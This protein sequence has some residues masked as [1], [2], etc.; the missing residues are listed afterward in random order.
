M[1]TMSDDFLL[2]DSE[3]EVSK[4]KAGHPGSGE[5][6]GDGEDDVF[7]LDDGDSGEE[8]KAPQEAGD[9]TEEEPAQ[10]KEAETRHAHLDDD[11]Y[12]QAP[13]IEFTKV[14]IPEELTNEWCLELIKAI[15]ISIL[16]ALMY[17]PD[18]PM[19]FKVL[20][21]SF[22]LIRSLADEYEEF[23][24]GTTE[25]KLF[26]ENA[27]MDEKDMAVRKFI[28]ILKKMGMDSVSFSSGIEVRELAKLFRILGMK[29]EAV[30]DQGGV[31]ALLT[32]SEAPHIKLEKARYERIVE[33]EAVVKI[34]EGEKLI[35][36]PEGEKVTVGDASAGK[37]GK[38]K[39]QEVPVF[40]LA[41]EYFK[42]EIQDISP[43]DEQRM[44][45]EVKK[46]PR[47]FAL[48]MI[49]IGKEIQN[50]QLVVERLG[51]LFVEHVG[52]SGGKEKADLSKL[53]MSIGKEIQK[54]MLHT[55]SAKDIGDSIQSLG[56]AVSR[57]TDAIKINAI[58]A[59]YTSGKKRSAAKMET[60]LQ[61]IIESDKEK[62][63]LLPQITDRLL[64][65]GMDEGKVK[66]FSKDIE[67]VQVGPKK[68]I[69]VEEAEL[70]S[71]LEYK[72]QAEQE[73]EKLRS[74]EKRLQQADHYLKNLT[75]APQGAGQGEDASAGSF[76]EERIDDIA[77]IAAHVDT[78]ALK[79][80]RPIDASE[81]EDGRM[82]VSKEDFEDLMKRSEHFDQLLN[83]RLRLATSRLMQEKAQIE[84]E[85]ET[86]NALIAKLAQGVIVV[87]EE[88]RVVLMNRY[89]EELLG[90]SREEM[91]G[92]HILD[93]IKDEHL[94][95]LA[96]KSHRDRE[97]LDMGDHIELSAPE[98][99][100]RKTI[101]S[102]TA[103]VQ[104]Q[105]G[106]TVGMLFVLTDVEKQR[107]LEALK[108]NFIDKISDGL[109]RPLQLIQDT[110]SLVANQT[111]GELNE[112]QQ[113]LVDITAQNIKRLHQ[114]I[115]QLV[116]MSRLKTG[117]IVLEKASHNI[118][119]VIKEAVEPFGQWASEK[120]IDIK[121]HLPKEPLIGLFDSQRIGQV[122]TNLVSN[123][124]N[125]SAQNTSVSIKAERIEKGSDQFISVAVSDAGEGI[126]PSDLQNIFK[127][128][129]QVRTATASRS[130]GMGLGLA[131]CRELIEL[132]GGHIWAE[133]EWG[134]G[135]I[136]TFLI[137]LK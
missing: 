83:E 93:G 94:V 40:Q 114:Q 102:S 92:R 65:M 128:F 9:G 32:Q 60:Y 67:K 79:A 71:L 43:E 63:R 89:A 118:A 106:R 135:S 30:E 80:G 129:T 10:Q 134:R 3:D 130:A 7:L 22:T 6:A 17:P 110:V 127:E 50:L 4:K 112:E 37:D 35:S 72:E 46:D 117:D 27:L 23:T 64:A 125:F 57:C 14:K 31:R 24:I 91:I 90:V 18:H 28:S 75:A 26:V 111:A 44:V 11:D 126:P 73:L 45:K 115:A 122:L 84:H 42:G 103:M 39:E 86:L 97:D 59:K 121:L 124:I 47:R 107:E 1:N 58:I 41:A 78:G 101:Q 99:S 21:N 113:R 29:P 34:N 12:E 81:L 15:N 66:K 48:L 88:D 87:D 120:K 20:Q 25:G 13:D 5:G 104:D 137:P 133:S 98:D 132:H 85:R 70:V 49:Q 119:H 56:D 36:V 82:A 95:A 116:D 55:G 105:H 131:L 2:P 76:S 8:E 62:N 61:K 136:F 77:R 53:M 51:K 19:I 123:A 108:M 68:K 69:S 38:K 96:R 16:Q 54:E 100:T 52:K 33:G 109:E 74:L